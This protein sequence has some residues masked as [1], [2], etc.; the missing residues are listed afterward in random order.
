MTRV[1]RMD[2]RP[3]ARERRL[4]ESAAEP[5]RV[6]CVEDV[7]D[8]CLLVIRAL[9]RA[10]LPLTWRRV[11]NREAFAEAIAR[12]AWDVVLCDHSLPGFNAFDARALLSA[13]GLDLPVI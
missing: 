7:E 10:G 3:S 4:G 6:L 1:Q 5:L 8:E 11:D 2:E 12:D 9:E 13:R